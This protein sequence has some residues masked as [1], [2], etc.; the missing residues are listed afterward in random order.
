LLIAGLSDTEINAIIEKLQQADPEAFAGKNVT[1]LRQE[2]ATTNVTT[3]G[4]DLKD[5]QA[6][7][8]DLLEGLNAT[9]G[10]PGQPAPSP[11]GELSCD[12]PSVSECLD[13][14]LVH[15]PVGPRATPVD[16]FSLHMLVHRSKSAA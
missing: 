2:L 16:R 1:E 14:L 15:S 10:A 3:F 11:P 6:V 5:M 12:H 4:V 13:L 9:Q 7:T 8:S